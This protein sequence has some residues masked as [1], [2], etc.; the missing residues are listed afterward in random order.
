MR[1]GTS[2]QA[3]ASDTGSGLRLGG[4]RADFVAGLGRK[5]SD[6][7]GSLVRVREIPGDLP[8]REELRRKLH[9][10]ASGAKLM[11]FDAMERAVS[12]A[13]GTIDRAA[14][15]LALDPLDLDAIDQILEDLPALAWGDESRVSRV[16]PAAKP[17][18]P[19]YS[20]LVVGPA[21]IAEALLSANGEDARARFACESTPDA[22]A[23]FDLAKT[24]APDLVVLDADLEA[25]TELVD[26]LMDDAVTDAAPIVVV[27]SF[28]ESGEAARYVAM[29]VSKTLSKPTSKD[30][31]RTACVEALEALRVDC[32]APEIARVE[33][34]S[35]TA[36]KISILPPANE[37]EV[38]RSD[39]MRLRARGPAVEVR[40][41]GRRVVVA[42]DDPAVVWFMADLLKAAGCTVHEAFDG[43][44]ALEL[45]HRTCPDL[46]VADI[47]MP[48]IDGF[49]LCRALRRDVALRDVPVILLSWKDD[50]L[51]R[52]RELG[53]GAAGY[54]RKESD[55]RAILARIR[56]ALRPRARIEMRM[57]DDDGE[58]R[59]RMDGLTVR[60][61][62][63]IVCAMR[64]EARVTVRDASFVY[65]V[66][67][68]DGAP[69]KATR[70]AGD[71]TVLKGSRVL[72][73]MLG[74]GAGRF[75]VVSSNKAVEA[76]LDGNLA[77]QLA[78]PVARARAAMSLL[79]L[80]N[81]KKVGRVRLDEQALEEYL[82]ATPDA[83][84]ALA[85]RIA[86]GTPPRQLVI[87]GA[88]EASLV[89]DLVYDLAAR[90][91]IAAI[92][93][94]NGSDLLG[95][96]IVRLAEQGDARA[97]FAP[98]TPTPAPGPTDD[99]IV[100]SALLA[101]PSAAAN[102]CVTDSES[103]LCE[104][105]SPGNASSLEDAV[106]REVATR[107]PEPAQLGLPIDRPLAVDP[108]PAT[109]RSTP[110]ASHG[111]DDEGTPP[112][113]QIIALAEPTVID[114]T[115]YG[116]DAREP[117]IPIAEG[118]EPLAARESRATKTPFAVVQ[119][120]DEAPAGV[121]TKS[122]KP[123]AMLG[124]VAAT[125]AVVWGVMHYAGASPTKSAETSAPAAEHDVISGAAESVT[126]TPLVAGDA[127]QGHGLLTISA[128]GDMVVLVDGTE[129]GRGTVRI[130]LWAGTHEVRVNGPAGEHHKAVDVR[131]GRVAHVKF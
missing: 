105:P 102:D 27:G 106:L 30:A 94:A 2:G 39:R 130:P 108:V 36:G 44:Q 19:C 26:A 128:P 45:A 93:D 100:P 48:G 67:V 35:T 85:V 33:E 17:V 82:R 22:Q 84:R 15:D 92:D 58:V 53:A 99:E 96:E 114:D 42:D 129:R 57:R 98:R 41:T 122:R 89:E 64:P 83:A 86:E 61:L 126:Y 55:T 90:G 68:R 16:E 73:A 118:S 28:L 43:R 121:P 66:E 119:T 50:L 81:A 54:V 20:A 62:L 109:A 52:V 4:A 63:E 95:P 75:T 113:D 69:V 38:A 74:I 117:S 25:A 21:M 80:A 87:E 34:S 1:T 13:L 91:V 124:F 47:M 88:C 7:R 76:E 37:I 14:I 10:L 59:G 110:A 32:S 8:R 101:A 24:T 9:A 49:A 77:A 12:E 78:K 72:A 125:G 71:G 60:T 23:A 11:K 65:E 31:L 115:R 56:E 79:V 107:S 29:G 112:H 127:P 46:V 5:V 131:S 120:A 123:W 70:T 51:Q 103:P 104:S 18:V 111:A 3:R 40:L 6:L 116:E 97:T